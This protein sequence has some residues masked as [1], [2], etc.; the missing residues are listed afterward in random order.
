MN[1]RSN[2]DER[3]LSLFLYHLTQEIVAS[4]DYSDCN[5]TRICG[6]YYDT[7][8][9]PNKE[10]LRRLITELKRKLHLDQSHQHVSAST[11]TPEVLCRCDRCREA[12]Q[13]QRQLALVPMDPL[14]LDKSVGTQSMPAYF[15]EVSTVVR[16][17]EN[18]PL[19][20]QESQRT[21]TTVTPCGTFCSMF[22]A[23]QSLSRKSSSEESDGLIE[24]ILLR[25][26][27]LPQDT[28]SDLLMR[29]AATDHII[30]D[31]CHG[32]CPL[33][34]CQL[35]AGA[36]LAGPSYAESA[37]IRIIPNRPTPRKTCRCPLKQCGEFAAGGG[38]PGGCPAGCASDAPLLR[39]DAGESVT[40]PINCCGAKKRRKQPIAC[41][42]KTDSRSES[43]QP[44]PCD[45]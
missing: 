25:H 16:I 43:K 17:N 13:R 34:R 11:Q 15:P 42:G 4:Q 37:N 40:P 38:S 41:R 39:Q 20:S 45:K 12:R 14:I 26:K 21:Y 6:K 29:M 28:S 22:S 9:Y 35:I 8:S 1:I 36:G 33:Q 3:E 19:L 18:L 30:C 44:G 2:A 23:G 32:K 27:A 7:S 10:R 24:Q 5:I 31:S